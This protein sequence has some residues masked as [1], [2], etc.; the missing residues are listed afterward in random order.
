MIMVVSMLVT[1]CQPAATATP[2]PTKKVEEPYVFGIVM[3][4]PYNDKGWNTA[5]YVA[6]QYVEKKMNAKMI[7][8]DKVN[9]A[10]RPGT[11]PAQIAEELLGQGAKFIIFD[12]DDMKDS[13]TEFVK[14]HPD[15]PVIHSSG[16][17][18][19]KDGKVYQELPNLVNVMGEMEYGK[20]MAGCAAA[21]TTKTGKIG[22]LG[23]LINDETRRLVSGAYLG[24]KYCWTKVLGKDIKD[25]QMKV[26]WIGFWFNIPGFTSDPT[27][28]ADD[29]FNN[30][31]DVLLSGIDT[32]EALTEA[33]K[34]KDQGKEVWAI[35]YDYADACAEAK[36]VCL[37]VPYFN[38]GPFYL[39][40]I[41]E[42]QKG[43]FKQNFEWFGP[44]WKDINNPD[45]SYVGFVKGDALSADNAAKVD[46][47]I[48]ELGG[49]LDLW[50]GPINLQDGTNYIEDGKKATPF[51]IWY[52]PQLLEGIEGQSV[53]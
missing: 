5:H 46:A 25:L 7:Y 40:Y 1:A 50:A 2:E 13:A 14:A 24:A 22:Y 36:D 47:F 51:Q 32:T 45:T 20:M 17:V 21:L 3:V 39:R 34:M 11:T 38:W 8:I 26:T 30:G 31:Y 44:D 52:L 15:I 16:D 9:T 18:S 6:G 49:G 48:T 4:G 43:T 33:K 41:Q 37:G 42:A 27:Q 12:S 19:W 10:D 23:P 53:Q 28:V 29:F 35:P